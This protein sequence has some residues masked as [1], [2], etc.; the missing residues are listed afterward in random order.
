MRREWRGVLPW[1][2]CFRGRNCTRAS[3]IR[4][5]AELFDPTG[6][7]TYSTA[8]TNTE[9][10]TGLLD[11]RRDQIFWWSQPCC[12]TGRVSAR[13]VLSLRSRSKILRCS[14]APHSHTLA[15]TRLLFLSSSCRLHVPAVFIPSLTRPCCVK[16]LCEARARP[17][18]AL[19]VTA[20]C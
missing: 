10:T 14:I 9:S 1:L 5:D 15:A 16:G 8:S 6:R 13:P 20:M 12:T 2:E 3:T 18:G 11:E 19:S 17:S 7:G 4:I